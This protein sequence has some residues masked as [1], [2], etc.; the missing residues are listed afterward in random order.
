MI[1]KTNR[2]IRFILTTVLVIACFISLSSLKSYEADSLGSICESNDISQIVEEYLNKMRM[3][4]F[5][6][7][8]SGFVIPEFAGYDPDVYNF[9]SFNDPGFRYCDVISLNVE[10]VTSKQYDFVIQRFGK[11]A[12][13]NAEYKIERVKCPETDGHLYFYNTVS[14][15]YI[16]EEEYNEIR[17]GFYSDLS[18]GK[19]IDPIE[20]DAL[21]AQTIEILLKSNDE[22]SDR[23]LTYPDVFEA[24]ASSMGYTA[25]VEIRSKDLYDYF[26]VYFTFDGRS[27]TEYGE[28]AF[29]IDISNKNGRFEICQG[30]KWN[31]PL[32]ENGDV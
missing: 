25:P 21:K 1:M 22:H 30:L 24:T 29:R 23:V 18:E 27:E 9:Q 20:F 32:I 3:S 8:G 11:G 19:G 26:I 14:E 7:T 6:E 13:V 5:D 28:C 15:H 10:E 12:W 4:S 17:S 16:S 2:L 31:I